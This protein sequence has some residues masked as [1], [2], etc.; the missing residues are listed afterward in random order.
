MEPTYAYFEDR[1]R[2]RVNVFAKVTEGETHKGATLHLYIPTFESLLENYIANKGEFTS[3][4]Y[5]QNTIYSIGALFAHLQRKFGTV[6][7][8]MRGGWEHF[9][10]A[11]SFELRDELS[12]E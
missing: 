2:S 6:L 10:E 1:E 11:P 12:E 3:F 5:Y 7:V 4:I 8:K 9:G